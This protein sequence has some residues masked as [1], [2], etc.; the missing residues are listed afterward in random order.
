MQM[1]ENETCKQL[2]EPALKASG[3]PSPAEQERI[4]AKYTEVASVT[5]AISAELTEQTKDLNAFREAIL[6]E[7]FAGNL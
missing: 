5:S 3:C 2:I 1:N 4:E 7:A 6:R